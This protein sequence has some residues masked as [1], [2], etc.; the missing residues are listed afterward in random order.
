VKIATGLTRSLIVLHW[1]NVVSWIC[2]GK[3]G[4][5]LGVDWTGVGSIG[6][7]SFGYI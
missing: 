6:R 2:R 5:V 3:R 1:K 4:D 7:R